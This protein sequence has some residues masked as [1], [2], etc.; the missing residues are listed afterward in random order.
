[1]LVEFYLL[2]PS[3]ITIYEALFACLLIFASIATCMKKTKNKPKPQE[4]I[5][6]GTT[7]DTKNDSKQQ[8]SFPKILVEKHDGKPSPDKPNVEKTLLIEFERENN[9]LNKSH[10]SKIEKE[11][12][13]DNQNLELCKTQIA[14]IDTSVKS[15]KTQLEIPKEVDEAQAQK[16]M[17]SSKIPSSGKSERNQKDELVT[18]KAETDSHATSRQEESS[19]KENPII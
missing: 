16:S 19:T 18:V 13:A 14:T 8:Q 6:L 15:E 11:T 7:I 9:Q 3:N 5:V 17:E 1:M 4:S 10:T 2:F 12:A